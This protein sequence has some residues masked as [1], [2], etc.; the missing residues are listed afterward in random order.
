[1]CCVPPFFLPS[2]ADMAFQA[3]YTL[4][5][6]FQLRHMLIGGRQDIL[7][8]IFPVQSVIFILSQPVVRQEMDALHAG[9]RI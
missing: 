6:A 5:R 3:A 1:M 9:K 2:S 8:E 7:H 4:H